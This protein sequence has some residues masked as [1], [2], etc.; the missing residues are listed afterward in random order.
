MP[1]SLDACSCL[2]CYSDPVVAT[3]VTRMRS[4]I[5][6]QCMLVVSLLNR[7]LA[8]HS[9]QNLIHFLRGDRAVD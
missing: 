3:D 9:K 4:D 1:L 5:A 7:L 8:K 2:Y 6:K